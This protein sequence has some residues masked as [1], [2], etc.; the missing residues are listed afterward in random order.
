M[1]KQKIIKS[2]L[3]LSGALKR[4]AF[5]S[6]H[7]TFFSQP[8]KARHLLPLLYVK[9]HQLINFYIRTFPS[10]LKLPNNHLII[11]SNSQP[12]N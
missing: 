7:T 8:S 9:G 3:N 12:L 11:K 4:Y 5:N 2:R 1:K 6:T 10:P